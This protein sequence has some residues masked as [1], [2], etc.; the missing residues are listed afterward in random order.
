MTFQ[1]HLRSELDTLSYLIAADHGRE[2]AV[3]DPTEDCLEAYAELGR[4]L[5]FRLRWSLETGAVAASAKAAQRLHEQTGCTRV[6]PCD[7]HRDGPVV[8]VGHLDRLDAAGLAVHVL[9]RPGCVQRSVAYHVGDRV[10]VGCT[11]V[12]GDAVL[13]AL[14]ADTLVYRAVPQRGAHLGLLALERG[15]SSP[16]RARWRAQARTLL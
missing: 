3:I 2:A 6:V 11:D 4:R 5:G 13:A 16:A 14:P 9:G 12:R 10:F 1:V 7:V 15:V 8:R